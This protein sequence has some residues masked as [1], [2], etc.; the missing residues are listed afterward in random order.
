LRNTSFTSRVYPASTEVTREVRA[1]HELLARH[2]LHRAFVGARD[3]RGGERGA[4]ALRAAGA[5]DADGLEPGR[6]RSVLGI[7]V[8]RDDV[9]GEIL[10][11]DRQLAA[12]HEVD[13][14]LSR[15]LRR[16]GEP[17]YFVVIGQR[18]H[19][20]AAGAA[21]RTTAAGDKSPSERVEWQ[22]RS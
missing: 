17:R 15:R 13:P 12:R 4:D 11:V 1:R 14:G 7:D 19:V 18:K 6:Q 2:V 16:L 20:D 22:C 3:A 8:E 10:P 21:R 5:A 9:D